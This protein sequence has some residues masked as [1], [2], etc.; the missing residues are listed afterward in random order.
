M[1]TAL[2]SSLVTFFPVLVNSLSG[3][4][5]IPTQV[6]ELAQLVGLTGVRKFFQIQLPSLRLQIINGVQLGALAGITAAV[7]GEMIGARYGLG[8]VIVR[9]QE[10]ADTAQVM[11]SL[12]ILSFCGLITW[13]GFA[14]ISQKLPQ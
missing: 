5:S 9:G 14:W 12:F 6:N 8:Y 7:I 4:R 3:L 2:V 11:V 10:S 1:N 13:H